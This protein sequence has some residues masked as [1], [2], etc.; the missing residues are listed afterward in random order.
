[1]AFSFPTLNIIKPYPFNI[2]LNLHFL[3]IVPY[4]PMIF[5]FYLPLAELGQLGQ[6]VFCAGTDVGWRL[7]AGG[8]AREVRGSA[9]AVSGVRSAAKFVW[10]L[11]P[12]VGIH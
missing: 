3:P 2:Y 12:N 10:Q 11:A 5:Q 7:P 4:F 1:M 8:V 6:L 9:G